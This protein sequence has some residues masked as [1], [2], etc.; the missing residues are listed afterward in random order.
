M[1]AEEE[2]LLKQKLAAENQEEAE[3]DAED[4]SIREDE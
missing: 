1:K 3:S 2:E 4:Q